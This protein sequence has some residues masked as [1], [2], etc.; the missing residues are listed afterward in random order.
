MLGNLKGLLVTLSTLFPQ[1][2]DLPVPRRPQA[3]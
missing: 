1:T 3:H 2:G